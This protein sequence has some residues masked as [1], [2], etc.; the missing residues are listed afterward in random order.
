MYLAV[1]CC[2]FR[3][4]FNRSVV[5]PVAVSVVTFSV[6]HAVG[7]DL[8]A[9]VVFPSLALFHLLSW[10]VFPSLP[11]AICTHTHTHK[12]RER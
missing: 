2:I 5:T 4:V 11:T 6:Y 12:E 1:C 9:A 3:Q 10:Y 7:Y 8:D